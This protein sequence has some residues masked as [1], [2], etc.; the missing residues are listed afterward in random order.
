M[1]MRI[2]GN[3][4]LNPARALVTTEI[5]GQLLS[6]NCNNRPNTNIRPWVNSRQRAS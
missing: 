3:Q 1:K 5:G 4:Q 2:V 6:T